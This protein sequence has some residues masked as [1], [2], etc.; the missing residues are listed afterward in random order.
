M[1]KAR[2]DD[3]KSPP[4]RLAFSGGLFKSRSAAAGAPKKFGCT[5]IFEEKW[6][7][8]LEKIIAG[9]IVE[10]WGEKGLA[11]AKVGA[12]R[13]PILKGDGK[14]ARSQ[15]SGE[16]HPGFGPGLI[17]IRT[18]A[19]EDRQPV[20]RWDDPNIPATQEQVYSGCYGFAVLNAFAWNHPQSGDGVSFG[21]RYFQKTK[22]GDSIGGIKPLDVDEYFEH[23]GGDEDLRD[24]RTTG[25]KGADGLFG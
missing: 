24:K 1:A 14:E 10:E 20:V 17:F 8:Q 19:N 2:S 23:V 7:P 12:I 3:F 5:L 13:N 6:R 18:Q 11:R 16:L 21:I 25:G 15:Q 9:V 22:D 4:C